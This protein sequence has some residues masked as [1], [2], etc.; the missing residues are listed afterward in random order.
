L[1]YLV[2][3]V[4]IC[5][6]QAVRM[7]TCHLLAR[8]MSVLACDVFRIRRSVVDENLRHAFPDWSRRQRHEVARGMWEHL[9]LMICEVAHVPRKI[10]DTNWRRYIRLHQPRPMAAALLKPHPTVL[11]TGHFGNFEVCGYISGLFGFPTYSVARPLDNPYLD[12]FLSR[13][14]GAT[15]QYVLPKQGSAGQVAELLDAGATLGLL[16]DQNAGPKGC[17]VEFLGREASCHKAIALFS[18]TTGAPLMVT[19]TRRLGRPMQ[20]ELGMVDQYDP[21]QSNRELR[22]V[23]D[24]TQ[25]YCRLLEQVVR[26]DPDQYWWLHR[27][28]KDD[29]VKRP[30]REAKLRRDP[31]QEQAPPDASGRRRMR[32]SGL[33][34]ARQAS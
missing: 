33:P 9:V 29:R 18:L 5:V 19:Y 8:G 24:L 10:R 22:T 25:W 21:A 2:V 31:P 26:A 13:F 17:W 11:L 20:F 30:H 3:R 7:E 15:G 28:W 4:F 1:V 6:I 34:S 27:R 32:S 16:G 12:G 23:K 14:R